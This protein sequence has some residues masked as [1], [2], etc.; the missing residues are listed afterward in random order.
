MYDL[1][2]DPK[3]MYNIYNDPKFSET[4]SDLHVLLK[5]LKGKYRDQEESD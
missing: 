2:N 1:L 3:E 4:Q 5:K